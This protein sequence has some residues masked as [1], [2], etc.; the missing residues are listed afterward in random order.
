M[1]LNQLELLHFDHIE[2]EQLFAIFVNLFGR[3]VKK[4]NWIIR[5]LVDFLFDIYLVDFL[6]AFLRWIE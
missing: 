2:F 5:H 6:F 4:S 1:R 3:F